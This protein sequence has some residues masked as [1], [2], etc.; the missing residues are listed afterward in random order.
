MSPS[1]RLRGTTARLIERGVPGYRYARITRAWRVGHRVSRVE[2]GDLA[3]PRIYRVL[4]V[5]PTGVL[6][7]LSVVEA[8]HA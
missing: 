4:A 8:R 3:G 2:T 6:P 5:D 7:L 1:P